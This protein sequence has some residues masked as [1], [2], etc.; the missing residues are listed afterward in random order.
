MKSFLSKFNILWILLLYVKSTA[1]GNNQSAAI[2]NGF[3]AIPGE[4]PWHV[5]LKETPQGSLLC[6]G[7]VINN[8]WVLTAAHCILNMESVYMQFGTVEL[9][10]NAP[11]MTSTALF[12][13]PTYNSAAGDDDIGLIQLPYPLIYNSFIQPIPLVTSE[14][15]ANNDFIGVLA[16]ISGFGDYINK[17]RRISEWLLWGP[18]V[19]VSNNVCAASYG[20]TP[21]AHMCS[22][23]YTVDRQHPCKGDSGGALVW[24][25]P[26]NVYKQIGVFSYGRE[27][28]CAGY[29]SGYMRVSSYLDFIN[30]I[31][32]LNFN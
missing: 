23:G 32:S 27:T 20:P 7:S 4:Y 3:R 31:T 2:I 24:R 29:P 11:S 10:S 12:P 6:G 17:V 21:A 14:E 15:A 28:N 18:E 1:A 19:V 26:M 30:N 22:V 13:H 9:F 25:N 8:I 5:L 16:L